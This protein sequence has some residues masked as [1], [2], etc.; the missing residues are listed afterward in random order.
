MSSLKKKKGESDGMDRRTFIKTSGM[1]VG[2]MALGGF[3]FVTH[4]QASTGPLNLVPTP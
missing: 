1:A 2:G 3:H 4:S